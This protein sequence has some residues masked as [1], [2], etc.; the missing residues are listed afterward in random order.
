VTFACIG[1]SPRMWTFPLTHPVSLIPLHMLWKPHSV[2]HRC[3][4]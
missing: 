1:P 2:S 4:I 3:F